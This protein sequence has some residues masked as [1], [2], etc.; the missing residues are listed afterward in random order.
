MIN[1]KDFD[2]LKK[3]LIENFSNMRVMLQ[4]KGI[5]NVDITMDS[6]TMTFT[7]NKVIMTDNTKDFSIEL[8]TLKNIVFFDEYRVQL[9]YDDLV[10]TVEI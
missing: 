2:K 5:V 3:V 10:V 1:N 6:P 7:I 8:A 4:I 9:I